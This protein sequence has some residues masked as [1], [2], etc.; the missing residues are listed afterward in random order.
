MNHNVRQECKELR[1]MIFITI[2]N[3]FEYSKSLNFKMAG[4]FLLRLH[5]NHNLYRQNT[6]QCTNFENGLSMESFG[7]F[8]G[9]RP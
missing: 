3:T 1:A 6:G 9:K 5:K 4:Q 8:F 7:F 2:R